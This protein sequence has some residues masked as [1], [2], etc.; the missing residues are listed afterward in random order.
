[1]EN[2]T[3]R[4]RCVMVL[5]RGDEVLGE[6]DGSV[7]GRIVDAARGG[8]GF[9]YD[10]FFV[11]DGHDADLR[12]AGCGGEEHPEPSGPGAGEAGAV[13]GGQV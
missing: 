13:A 12:G 1:M 9:G 11:P 6:F 3:A 5:A 2:R 8:G 10:P 4:F 7:E